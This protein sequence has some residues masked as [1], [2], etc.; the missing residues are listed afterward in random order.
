MVKRASLKLPTTPTSSTLQRRQESTCPIR[1]G[2][3]LAAL[4]QGSWRRA[5]LTSRMARSSTTIK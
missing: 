4:V 2:R 5:R 1:A 3:G